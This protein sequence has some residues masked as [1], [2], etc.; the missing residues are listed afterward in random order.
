MSNLKD[1]IKKIVKDK[2]PFLIK[3]NYSSNNLFNEFSLL[4]ISTLNQ[5]T[6]G[7]KWIH[8]NDIDRC[9]CV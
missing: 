7:M 8:D 6:S 3:E 2:T 5:L 9:V 4:E 1:H